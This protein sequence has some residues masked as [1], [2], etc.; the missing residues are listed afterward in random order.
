MF[1]PHNAER[2]AWKSGKRTRQ[3]GCETEYTQE[4][5]LMFWGGGE[6]IASNYLFVTSGLAVIRHHPRESK[7][8]FVYLRKEQDDARNQSN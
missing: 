3:T 4:R 6:R 8:V 7:D 1:V 2:R 5:L